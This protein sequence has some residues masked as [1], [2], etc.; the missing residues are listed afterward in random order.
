M[1]LDYRLA[2]VIKGHITKDGLIS[3]LLILFCIFVSR[4]LIRLRFHHTIICVLRSF[5]ILHLLHFIHNERFHSTTHLLPLPLL[6]IFDHDS[7]SVSHEAGLLLWSERHWGIKF[8]R[9]FDRFESIL[10]HDVHQIIAIF[11]FG[12]LYSLPFLA[13]FCNGRFSACRAITFRRECWDIW[14]LVHRSPA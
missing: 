12:F 14:R 11:G 8:G 2:L 5:L 6:S 3:S 9:Q 1:I 10:E 13:L 4:V 7:F